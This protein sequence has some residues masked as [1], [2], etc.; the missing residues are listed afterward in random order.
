MTREIF[1]PSNGNNITSVIGS[2][3]GGT[4]VTTRNEVV[5]K[6]NLVGKETIGQPGGPVPLMSGK[7]PRKYIEGASENPYG[8]KIPTQVAN[9]HSHQFPIE[10]CD[11]FTQYKAE[12]DHGHVF[13]RDS[14]VH[15]TPEAGY[16]GE[17]VLTFEGS[18][19]RFFSVEKVINPPVIKSLKREYNPDRLGDAVEIEFLDPR[20]SDGSSADADLELAS[21]VDS[22]GNPI[23]VNF[24]KI[25]NNKYSLSVTS[26]IFDK[27]VFCFLYRNNEVV[28]EVTEI[29]IEK[30]MGSG[31]V[32]AFIANT[33]YTESLR[34]FDIGEEHSAGLYLNFMNEKII[35]LYRL[36][37]LGNIELIQEISYSNYTW[38]RSFDSN[39]D[40]TKIYLSVAD[41]TAGKILIFKRNERKKYSLFK[42]IETAE[43]LSSN[44][45]IT[46]WGRNINGSNHSH[47]FTFAVS[48][49]FSNT[50][51][52]YI[53]DG[54]TGQYV[55]SVTLPTPG[56]PRNYREAYWP[57][58]MK[59]GDITV[60]QC[61]FEGLTHQGE[62]VGGRV[63]HYRLN[64]NSWTLVETIKPNLYW[65]FGSY[66]ISSSG[67]LAASVAEGS[68]PM[69]FVSKINQQNQLIKNTIDTRI[70]I[71]IPFTYI[72]A[73]K[74]VGETDAVY[75]IARDSSWSFIAIYKFKLDADTLTVISVEKIDIGSRGPQYDSTHQYINVYKNN[76][77]LL[78]KNETGPMSII[79]ILNTVGE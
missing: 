25:E 23:D 62:N 34:I 31:V 66:G 59:N 16:V 77:F 26:S 39:V 10:M 54:E 47:L 12:V 14:F 70:Y 41:S 42:T 51:I 72:M 19:F 65:A 46:E 13:V 15:Y 48:P 44:P 18:E 64:N 17:V 63:L 50:N 20:F 61:V 40:G 67:D 49:S 38:I 36:E 35:R 27:V 57:I 60:H 29:A 5:Q 56:E 55:N 71:N 22:S 21:S 30:P 53:Y 28:S 45:G 32:N 43:G 68:Y 58:M 1:N 76:V 11:A 78:S 2:R 9:K 7:V 75:V 52:V 6:F 3:S 73:L 79:H 69:L 24:V 37:D 74:C 4:G 8:L 33:F